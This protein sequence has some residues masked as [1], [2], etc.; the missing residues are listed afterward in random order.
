MKIE[1]IFKKSLTENLSYGD[2]ESFSAEEGVSIEDSF[3]QVSL[4][5]A[6]KFDAGEMSYEDG[7]NAMNGV[8]PIMLDFTM[9]HD[10]PLV[11][12]CYEIYCAFDA[13]EYDHRDQC[14]PV[15][16]YTKPAIKEALRNA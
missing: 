6:R 9:K 14:D 1:E 7:D 15:E 10:I 5:I 3:N 4:F 16:K 13:G 12:P 8:W 2:F 11:E